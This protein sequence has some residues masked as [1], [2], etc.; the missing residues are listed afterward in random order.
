MNR[1]KAVQIAAGY[2]HT[3]IMA[4][5][6]RELFWFGT[7]GELTKQSTPVILNLAEKIPSLYPGTTAYGQSIS[8]QI[9]FAN[10]KVSCSW[11]K[12]I[13]TTN[14]MLADLRAIN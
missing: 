9:D 4:E 12:T 14:L 2:S 13:S 7:S 8:Q 6:S 1:D 3:V 11:S 5:A 10:V